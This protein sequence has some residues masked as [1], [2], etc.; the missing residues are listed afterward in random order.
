[1]SSQLNTRYSIFHPTQHKKDHHLSTRNHLPAAELIAGALAGDRLALARCI[2][3]VENETVAS[4]AILRA[5]FAHTGHA[6]IIGVTGAPGT[7]KSTLVN[8]LTQEYRREGM[9]VAV[10][11]IDPT[12]PFTGGAILGDRVRMRSLSGDSGVFIRSMATRGSLGGLSKTTADVVMVL[13]AAGYDRIIVE[14]VGVGQAEVEVARTAHTTLVIEAPGMGDEVQAIKAGILEIG[15]ILVVNKADREGVDRTVM[16]LEMML[17]MG[18]APRRVMHHGQLMS[19]ETPADLVSEAD[20]WQVKVLKTV[21][22]AGTGVPE[23]RERID[24]HRDHLLATGE[25]TV[26]ERMRMANLL[27]NIMRAELN[28]RILA[29]LPTARLDATVEQVRNRE[30]DPYSAA[31]DLLRDV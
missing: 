15:D 21:A 31:D 16:A 14:T 9:T 20:A 11:A 12:S 2:S 23:L 25:M 8:A 17:N 4:Q 7:G 3:H 18:H 29:R 13:D 24:A 6:H 1:M 10:V 19:V 28:R 22:A 5:L 30:I 26:R 27:E